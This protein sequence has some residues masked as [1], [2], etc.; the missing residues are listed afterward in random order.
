MQ[1]RIVF[2]LYVDRQ[3]RQRAGSVIGGYVD[4]P[5]DLQVERITDV[6]H[7]PPGPLASVDP[8]LANRPLHSSLA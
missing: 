6:A 1:Q 4:R 5:L 2:A 8:S 3:H 7:Q